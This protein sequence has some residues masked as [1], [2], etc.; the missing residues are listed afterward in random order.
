M[1]NK[2]L[3]ALKNII[4]YEVGNKRIDA[5]VTLRLST[6]GE[7]MDIWAKDRT[8]AFLKWQKSNEWEYGFHGWFNPAMI[9]TAKR[10]TDEQLYQQFLNDTK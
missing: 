3:D 8:I 1:N 9:G 4:G 7:A 2:Q 10:L 5:K 6:M